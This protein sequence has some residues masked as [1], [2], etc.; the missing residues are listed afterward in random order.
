MTGHEQSAIRDFAHHAAMMAAMAGM[1]VETLAADPDTVSIGDAV[2]GLR[3][4]ATRLSL[5]LSKLADP[6]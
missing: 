4:M 5:D 2:D 1:M 3:T 6:A